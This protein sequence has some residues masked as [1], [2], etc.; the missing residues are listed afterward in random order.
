M[1]LIQR[2]DLVEGGRVRTMPCGHRGRDW[3]AVA[4]GQGHQ[5]WMATSRGLEG[6]AWPCSP[7]L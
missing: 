4:A 1:G 7:G 5:E 6:E 2:D 3:S